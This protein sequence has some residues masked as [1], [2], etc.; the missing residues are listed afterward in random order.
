MATWS[1]V[2]AFAVAG[3]LRSICSD[4]TNIFYMLASGANFGG[5]ARAGDYYQ[6]EFG[7]GNTKIVDQSNMGWSLTYGCVVYAG[8]LY[9]LEWVSGDS[10]FGPNHVGNVHR[11]NGSVD[12]TTIVRNSFDLDYSVYKGVGYYRIFADDDGLYTAVVANDGTGEGYRSNYY[13]TEFYNG[14]WSTST[15]GVDPVE[16]STRTTYQAANPLGVFEIFNRDSDGT[17]W[18]ARASGSAAFS[19]YQ[20]SPPAFG[21]ILG[22]NPGGTLHF[23]TLISNSYY[24]NSAMSSMTQIPDI[25]CIQQYNM[26]YLC[27]LEYVGPGS[28]FYTLSESGPSWTLLELVDEGAFDPAF[29]VTQTAVLRMDNGNVYIF[30]QNINTGFAEIWLRSEPLN[31]PTYDRR[32]Y[33]Y[34][35]TDSGDSWT[36][37]K[38]ET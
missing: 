4:G 32:L 10:I 1:R 28:N 19:V 26:P 14:S 20:G 11:W 35:T 34:K 3:R 23:G 21:S 36:V 8:D 31:P 37:R 7:V 38:V 24:L 33:I 30:G 15:F 16:G 29:D 5:Y 2:A 9:M 27:G 17:A 6:Y 22:S 12:S 13:L 25:S 18:V